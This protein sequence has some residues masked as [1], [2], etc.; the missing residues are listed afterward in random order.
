MVALFFFVPLLVACGGTAHARVVG[1]GRAPDSPICA[2]YG[3]TV[4]VGLLA[5][6]PHD[7]GVTIARLRPRWPKVMHV[8][9]EGTK[10]AWSGPAAAQTS[11]AYAL[12]LADLQHAGT[13]ID[14]SDMPGFQAA[15]R[16]AKAHLVTV[17]ALA[18]RSHRTCRIVS[19]DGSTMTFG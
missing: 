5:V 8:A 14:R 18:K 2:F 7:P 15:I 12:F 9:E 10:V 1:T 19:P 13:A 16:S 17:E 6:H 4:A 3:T 11:A